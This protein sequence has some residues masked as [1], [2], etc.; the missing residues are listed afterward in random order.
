MPNI[1]VISKHA[2]ISQNSKPLS[3]PMLSIWFGLI[4]GY[5]E[6]FLLL[7]R[8]FYQHK[9]IFLS[10]HFPWLVLLGDLLIFGVIGLLLFV[11]F[12]RRN[13]EI[14]LRFSY[15][16]LSFTFAMSLLLR[17]NRLALWSKFILA[18]GLGVVSVRLI[19][20]HKELFYSTA[21][22]TLPMLISGV[23]FTAIYMLVFTP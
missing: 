9:I 16:L 8:K 18:F 12:R 5:G 11:I 19:E 22:L 13:S 17:I 1:F 7:F 15:W 6:I 21:R 20:A 23:L 14:T 2:W 4:A 10:H 3:I